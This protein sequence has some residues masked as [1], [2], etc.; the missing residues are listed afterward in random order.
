MNERAAALPRRP[1][2]NDRVRAV[3]PSRR[4]LS[5]NQLLDSADGLA[6][7]SDLRGLMVG[8]LDSERILEIHQQIHHR[9]RI[10]PKVDE[11]RVGR[12]DVFTC[13]EPRPDDVA[14]AA[15]DFVGHRGTIPGAM[16]I[17]LES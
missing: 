12:K 6:H 16:T 5:Q 7:G 1:D 4:S 15:R 11:R 8:N 14:Y 13:L 3:S 9:D 17:S 2:S 10:C